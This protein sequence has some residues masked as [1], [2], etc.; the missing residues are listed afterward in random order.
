[1]FLPGKIIWFFCTPS[2]LLTALVA[3]GVILALLGWRPRQ[4]MI[5]ATVGAL[6][7]LI[8]GLSP[9]AY[10]LATALETRFPP[11]RPM[12]DQI[13]GIVVLGGGLRLYDSARRD[14]LFLS[15]AG[16]RL[17]A[18]ADLARRYPKA[19]LVF[20][21]GSGDLFN[22]GEVE[23]DLV[24]AHAPTLGVDPS[25]ILVE[26]RSR[27]TYENAIYTCAMVKP[28]QGEI[29]LLV[30]SAWH[31]PR[32]VGAFRQAG[33]PV[34]AYPVDYRAAGPRYGWRMFAEVA[35]GLRMTDTMA[36]E[37]FGMIAY[38][39]MGRTDAL[40]PSPDTP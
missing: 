13:T 12:P 19:K 29:W 38:W 4:S 2:N 5:A 21:G 33:F 20:S 32:A 23:S 24:R 40:L 9:V 15:E 8:F 11:P 37:W 27:S 17:V 35:A 30:T 1:M 7:L 6:G 36:K 28:G 22:E 18:L 10:W 3:G 39:L 34:I 26:N 25:R 16:D 14:T 31:M